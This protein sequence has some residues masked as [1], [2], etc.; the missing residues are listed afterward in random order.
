MVTADVQLTLAPAATYERLVQAR[1]SGSARALAGRIVLAVAVI[2]TSVA[3]AATGRASVEL[4][5]GVG[6][7]W[8]FAVLIQAVAAAAIILP[9]RRRAVTALRAFELW[10]QAHVPWSLWLL[11]PAIVTVASGRK[12]SDTTLFVAALAPAAWTAVLLRAFVLRVLRAPRA[13]P[14]LV[15]HQFVLWGL[16]LCYIAFAI[17]GWDRV[18]AE[19]G[20]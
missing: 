5:A 14:M 7:S 18:L 9:A 11:L 19:I 1:R 3:I 8:S 12:V 4:V 2:G 17:G 13:I 16:T 10:F 15:A 6:L 20:L